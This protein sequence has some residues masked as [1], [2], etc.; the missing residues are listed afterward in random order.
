MSRVNIATGEVMWTYKCEG[1]PQGTTC[2]G[3]K[4]VLEA[5]DGSKTIMILD[6]KTGNYVEGLIIYML[7]PS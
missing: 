2:Y 7:H 1:S 5:R 4:Y 3:S 6:I